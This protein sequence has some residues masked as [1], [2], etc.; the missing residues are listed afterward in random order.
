MKVATISTQT[1]PASL[2]ADGY[3]GDVIRL[4]VKP[5]VEW[6][7][8]VPEVIVAEPV[9][10]SAVSVTHNGAQHVIAVGASTLTAWQEGDELRFA[11]A[12]AGHVVTTGEVSL[13]DVDAPAVR[14]CFPVAKHLYGLPEHTQN[15][16]MRKGEAYQMFNTDAFEYPLHSG[17]PKYGSIPFLMAYAAAATTGVLF[18][19]SSEMLIRVVDL[20]GALTV[21][22]TAEVGITDLF[23]IPGPTPSA[24]Q[25]HHAH[26][27]GPTFFPPYA[28]LG[29]HQCR[30]NYVSQEE[31]MSVEAGMSG[32]DLPYDVLWL[33]IE[34]SAAKKYFQFDHDAFPNPQALLDY[35]V[36]RGRKLV[37]I[38]DPHT[39]TEP[40]WAVY[41]EGLAGNHFVRTPDGTANFEGDC[42]PGNSC[43]PDFLQRRTREWY[44]SFFHDDRCECGGRDT[45]TWVDMNEPA[46]FHGY[47]ERTMIKEALHHADDDRAVQHRYL[48]NM[49]GFLSVLS[50]AQG[51]LEAAGPSAEPERPFLLTRSFFAGSQRLSGMWAGDNMARWDHLQC[52]MPELLSLSIA[53]YPFCGVDAGGFLREPSSELFQR[54]FQAAVFYP[55]FRGHA[56]WDTRHREP[57]VWEPAARERLRAALQLR[58]SL[59][60]Y[61]Y[62]VFYHAHT[63]GETVLRPLFYEFPHDESLAT[64]QDS[65]MFGPTLLVCPVVHAGATTVEVTL[66]TCTCWYAFPQG[67]NAVTKAG[68]LVLPVTMDSIPVYLRGG[69]VLAVKTQKRPSTVSAVNDPFTLHVALDANGESRGDLYLDDGRSF[70]Y[71]TGKVAHRL[72][73]YAGGKLTCGAAAP[74]SYTA[75]NTI[76]RVVVYGAAAPIS[77]AS[78]NGA[79]LPVEHAGDTTVIDV[80]SAPMRVDEGWSIEL[81]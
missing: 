22:W 75:P 11:F 50:A 66:P 61:L 46:V 72:F 73:T 52:S 76:E 1:V 59:I 29:Y 30:W 16:A 25:R 74:G 28:V 65:F 12:S 67:S 5:D 56:N 64:E 41:D 7:W 54:W 70:Q 43:W 48:H 21:R 9:A 42:W 34:Y 37:T 44:A 10:E 13:R 35:L 55:F 68:K 26:L 36:A 62:T 80:R 8:E 23:F 32:A 77:C 31:C 53:N 47:R 33:D 81:S 57:Y 51:C 45:Y 18:L 15:L 3:A 60:P 58:Y 19:N 79:P 17:D 69:H 71:K 63:R 78:S 38:K 49:Y 2:Y 6:V 40:G 14:M 4:R 20:P 24:V 27:T 39:K